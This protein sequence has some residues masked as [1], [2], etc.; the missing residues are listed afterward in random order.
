MLKLSLFEGEENAPFCVC[1]FKCKWAAP[2][3]Q[4]VE[5]QELVLAQT[6]TEN[7]NNF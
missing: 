3:A 7:F 6:C 2:P 1:S 4:G 5:L